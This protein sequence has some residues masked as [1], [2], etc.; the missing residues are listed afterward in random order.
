MFAGFIAAPARYSIS[1]A[2]TH[3][4]IHRLWLLLSLVV[5]Y[6]IWAVPSFPQCPPQIHG[7]FHFIIV[8]FAL[9]ASVAM[10][11]AVRNSINVTADAGELF[12]G[13][14]ITG[15]AQTGLGFVFTLTVALD[16]QRALCGETTSSASLVLGVLVIA[17]AAIDALL[18]VF[19]WNDPDAKVLS[20][21]HHV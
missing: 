5:M 17:T 10:P 4:V 3:V 11:F 2:R 15:V 6:T 19:L 8:F 20:D 12:L 21:G 14:A 9:L 7:P 1:L 18:A 13:S 16:Q